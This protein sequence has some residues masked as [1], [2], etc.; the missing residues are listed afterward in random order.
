M[1]VRVNERSHG[2]LDVCVKSHDLCCYTLQIT[3]NDKVF[4]PDF[5]EAVTDKIISLAFDIHAEVWG[6]N[7]VYVNSSESFRERKRMQESAAN[8]CNVLLSMIDISKSVF[9][10]E[11]KRVAYWGGKVIELRNQIREWKESDAD[12]YKRF[13]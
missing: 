7:N 4:T 2:K 6:A 5:K 1:A 10:L 12:R 13:K 9:H 8:K 3:K 11:S